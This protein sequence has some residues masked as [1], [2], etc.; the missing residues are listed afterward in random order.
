MVK[1]NGPMIA[2]AVSRLGSDPVPVSIAAGSTVAAALAKAG[3][4]GAKG[5]LFVDGSPANLEDV[6]ENGD[7]LNIVTPKEAGAR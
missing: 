4:E 6:L 5:E 7:V 1:K 3:I 2:V